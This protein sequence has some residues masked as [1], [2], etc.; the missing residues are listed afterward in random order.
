MKIYSRR[1]HQLRNIDRQQ[2]CTFIQQTECDA[3]FLEHE[4]RILSV[5]RDLLNNFQP[6][7]RLKVEGVHVLWGWWAIDGTG[8]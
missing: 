8:I 1:R 5:A 6:T 2:C 7:M 4:S 3:E